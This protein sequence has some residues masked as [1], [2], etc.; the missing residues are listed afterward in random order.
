MSTIGGKGRNRRSTAI[1]VVN[2]DVRIGDN[3]QRHER[4]ERLRQLVVGRVRRCEFGDQ[5]DEG[6]GPSPARRPVRP[7]PCR[8]TGRP[9]SIRRSY[10]SEFLTDWI[11]RRNIRRLL[12]PRAGRPALRRIRWR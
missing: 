3:E 8:P 9:A 5:S 2:S 12:V 10:R 7:A 6:A 1:S 11:I 4:R